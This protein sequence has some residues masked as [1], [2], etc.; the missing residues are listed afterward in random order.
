VVEKDPWL[1][2][3]IIPEL[4]TD[5]T[6]L[7]GIPSPRDIPDVLEAMRKIECD[8][9]WAKYYNEYDAYQHIRNFFLKYTKYT[10]LVIIPDD[11][12]VTPLHFGWLRFKSYSCNYPVL[13]GTC[14]AAYNTERDKF[15]CRKNSANDPP[16]PKEELDAFANKD[17]VQEMAFEGFACCFI[18]RD[19][20]EKIDFRG[21]FTKTAFDLTFAED[22]KRQGI[23][24]MVDTRIRILHLR[25]RVD[26]GDMECRG[27]GIYAPRMV[28]EYGH[29]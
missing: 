21:M 15:V 7:I 17:P 20:V 3:L 13:S 22:C 23:P 9:I 14:N 27:L 2:K 12:V 5:T 1:K 16:M 11:L 28:Y 26:G 6:T 4:D 19:V 24:V 8:K 25:N 18:R 10:H 29:F